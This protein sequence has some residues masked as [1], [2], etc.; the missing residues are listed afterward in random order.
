MSAEAAPADGV[1]TRPEAETVRFRAAPGQW[2]PLFITIGVALLPAVTDSLLVHRW[3][4]TSPAF[5]TTIRLTVLAFLVVV[6][7]ELWL[8]ARWFGVTLTS[9]AAV[10]HGLRRRT[11]PW[12]RV[13]PLRYPTSAPFARDRRFPEKAAFIGHWWLTHRDNGQG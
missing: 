11:I 4:G 8:V 10:V 2:L 12:N 1:M 3:P 9:Q 13:A 6:G 7:L 5:L